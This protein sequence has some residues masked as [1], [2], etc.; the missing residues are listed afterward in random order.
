MFKLEARYDMLHDLANS[1]IEEIKKIIS[2]LTSVMNGEIETI[3]L[4]GYDTTIVECTKDGCM[5]YHGVGHTTMGPIPARW[6]LSLFKDWLAYL[7]NFKE[8]E[9]KQRS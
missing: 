4:E 5:I 7:V 2:D 1:N 8:A 6:L 3:D 9:N